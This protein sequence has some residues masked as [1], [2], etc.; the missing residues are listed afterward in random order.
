MED[1]IKF[2]TKDNSEAKKSLAESGEKK[3]AAESDLAMTNKDLDTHPYLSKR[4]GYPGPRWHQ[5][6]IVP[7]ALKNNKK[8]FFGRMPKSKS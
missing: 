5:G 4:G 1:K 2:D 7:R 8:R 6:T 3:A